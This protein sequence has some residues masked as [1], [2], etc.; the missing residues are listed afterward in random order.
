[1]SEAA[2]FST[3]P[4]PTEEHDPVWFWR[5][6]AFLRL[7]FNA[8]QAQALADAAADYR[9]VGAAIKGGCPYAT[10]VLIFT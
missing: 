5:C 7:G 9:K 3:L 1:M 4:E 2:G 8:G 6:R 10:A